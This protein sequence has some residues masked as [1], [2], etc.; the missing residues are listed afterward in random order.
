MD[1]TQNNLSYAGNHVR[2]PAKLVIGGY[3]IYPARGHWGM[4]FG[5][6][7]CHSVEEAIVWGRTDPRCCAVSW[8]SRKNMAYAH[9][10][11][12]DQRIHHENNRRFAKSWSHKMHVL[13]IFG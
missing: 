1:F 10:A 9:Y 6:R 12:E 13:I 3:S 4:H 8:N 2:Y 11:I 5:N 7:E